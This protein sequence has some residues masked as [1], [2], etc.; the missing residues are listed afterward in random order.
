MPTCEGAGIPWIHQFAAPRR[1]QQPL[2]LAPLFVRAVE[3]GIR[4]RNKQQRMPISAARRKVVAPV[5]QRMP[6]ATTQDPHHPRTQAG[7]GPPKGAGS[8]DWMRGQDAGRPAS[9]PHQL[10]GSALPSS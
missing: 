7:G 1:Q 8:E 5:R 2:G 3:I 4:A 10:T 6:G 9:T